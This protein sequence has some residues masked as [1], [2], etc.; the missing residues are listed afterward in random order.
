MP[1]DAEHP[2]NVISGEALLSGQTVQARDIGEVHFHLCRRRAP[3][4][5]DE[6]L[7]VGVMPLAAESFQ[8]REAAA[9]LEQSLAGSGTAVLTGGGVLGSGVLS[10]MGGVGKTQLAA[11]YARRALARCVGV[12]VWVTAASGQA[13]IDAYA[14]AAAGLGVEGCEGRDAEGDAGRFLAW[15]ARTSREW[16]V[17]L[18]DIQDPGDV[19]DWWPPADAAGRVLATTR[20]RDAALSGHGRQIIPIDVYTPAE[21]HSYLTDRL[22]LVGPSEP[23]TELE[24]LAAELGHLPLALS[25]A[26]AY[27]LDAS[28][29]CAQYR[30]LLA[31]QDRTLADLA[32]DS[33]PD[34]HPQIVAATWALSVARANATRPEG[35]AGQLLE[36]VSVLDPNGI[37]QAV[38][39]SPSALAFLGITEGDRVRQGLRVLDRFSLITHNPAAADRE[40]RVHQLIQRATREHH[41]PDQP[42]DPDRTA[43]MANAAAD[44]LLHV[45]PD[46]ER[47]QLGQILR[48]NTTA[49]HHA[50]GNALC[51]STGDAH[52]VLFKA[53]NSLGEIGKV[54]AATA[55]VTELH[56]LCL[57]NLGPDHENTLR[58]RSGL[59]HWRGQAGD[60]AGAVAAFQDLLTDCLRVLG[61]DH[62]ATLTTRYNLAQWR[63]ATGDDTGAA[64]A[65]QDL[66]TDCLRGL[67]PDHPQTL[68]T[69][70]SQAFWRDMAGDAAGTA[71]MIQGLVTDYLRVLGPDHPKTLG[72]RNML[73]L[74]RGRAGDAAGAVA[75]LQDLV[76]DYLRV[77][78]PD[79]PLT[80]TTRL[81]LAVWQGDAG[82]TAGAVATLLDLVTDC[83]RVLG[84]DHPSTLIAC[85]NLVYRWNQL[86]SQGLA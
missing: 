54:A 37:P 72:A 24:G 79:H 48:A 86:D 35:L 76:T 66:L 15:T 69:R 29:T 65:F 39:T 9:R 45:W 78:G 83:L 53:A 5:G 84:P 75:A 33:L 60:E 6:S 26:A 64:T 85:R 52:K 11:A 56:S 41:G 82:D 74:S 59:A 47:D 16:L 7:L 73:G 31:D 44:A 8:E 20:R 32:P 30:A 49:L 80:L 13:V 77:L 21:A 4:D 10:G 25:Q 43:V 12:V 3:A 67:G 34:Q 50:T 23:A 27:M 81:N 57:H 1:D 63:G 71:A 17:V 51:P 36:L 28:M 19:K 38:L 2:Q 46:P 22:A 14:E 70:S 40:V 68:L 42:A 55:A 18:D 62:L 61:P 58:A